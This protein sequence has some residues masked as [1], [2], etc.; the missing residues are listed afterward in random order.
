M[1]LSSDELAILDYLKSWNGKS[2]SLVQICRSAASR[3]KFKDS[4]TWASGLMP[5]LVEAKLVGMNERGHYR[6]P[7]AKEYGV[8]GDDYFPAP[9]EPEP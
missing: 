8:L 6:I 4:P 9:R 2:I 1:I 7:K 3:K 5:R